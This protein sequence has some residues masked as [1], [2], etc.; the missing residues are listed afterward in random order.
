MR[1][2]DLAQFDEDDEVITIRI[3]PMYLE[4]IVAAL[5]H[6]GRKSH[7]NVLR[8]TWATMF[9]LFCLLE[10]FEAVVDGEQKAAQ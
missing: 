9:V 5:R 4:V 1:T 10:D 8:D 2:Y 7:R 6:C 3:H